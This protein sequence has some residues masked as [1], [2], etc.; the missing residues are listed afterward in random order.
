MM[1]LLNSVNVYFAE[2][3]HHAPLEK[4]SLQHPYNFYFKTFR[5]MLYIERHI[6]IYISLILALHVNG[7]L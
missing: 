7:H 5:R 3:D 6:Y 4:S 1:L 2:M